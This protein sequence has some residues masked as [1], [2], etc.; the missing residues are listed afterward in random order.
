VAVGGT[1]TISIRYAT[2]ATQPPFPD[3][4]ALSIPNNGSGASAAGT[5]PLGL[6]AR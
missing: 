1:C 4:G 2:P 3:P 5:T 6:S